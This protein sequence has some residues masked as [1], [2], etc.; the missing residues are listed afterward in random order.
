[1]TLNDPEEQ[2]AVFLKDVSVAYR[3]P[4]ERFASIKEYAIKKV[5]GKVRL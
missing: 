4:V 3:L 1:M 5:L 2:T